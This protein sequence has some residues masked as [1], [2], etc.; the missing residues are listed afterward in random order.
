MIHRHSSIIMSSF[1]IISRPCTFLVLS[2]LLNRK[3]QSSSSSNLLKEVFQFLSYFGNVSSDF[4]SLVLSVLSNSSKLRNHWFF[5][6]RNKSQLLFLQN[7]LLDFSFSLE[8]DQKVPEVVPLSTHSISV[9]SHDCGHFLNQFLSINNFSSVVEFSTGL[10][11]NESTCDFLAANLPNLMSLSIVIDK[12]FSFSASFSNLTCLQVCPSFPFQRLVL[13][14]S[15]LSN[16]K[17]LTF[18]GAQSCLKGLSS[19]SMLEHVSFYS[20]FSEEPFHPSVLL[21]YL[22]L[23]NTLVERASMLFAHNV[24][25]QHCSVSL[26]DLVPTSVPAHVSSQVV[27]Y[28]ISPNYGDDHAASFSMFSFPF[29]SRLLISSY[30]T[31]DLDLSCCSRL[32]ELSLSNLKS[33]NDTVTITSLLHV[34]KVKLFSCS[35]K[36]SH[37]ILTHSPLLRHLELVNVSFIST[38]PDSDV[39]YS[40]NYLE[41]L[42]LVSVEGFFSRLKKLPSLSC[43][44]LSDLRGV[45]SSFLS[46]SCRNLKFLSLKDCALQSTV[47]CAASLVNELVLSN[48]EFCGCT[49]FNQFIRL[50]D[51]RLTLPDNFTTSIN[52]PSSLLSLKLSCRFLAVKKS[53]VSLNKALVVSGDLAC[54]S[55]ELADANAFVANLSHL[56]PSTTIS[57]RITELQAP[58]MP[59]FRRRGPRG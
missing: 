24:H 41:T 21:K 35:L 10:V 28:S 54:S 11:C 23:S 6:S 29:I 2:S 9:S 17:K 32:Q 52:L 14:V 34:V 49:F 48:T 59:R 45:G 4:R 5:V 16:L 39:F 53:L 57:L 50:R 37:Q 25:Y 13:D 12:D 30:K 8:I 36:V 31:F 56:L 46:L 18:T 3:D 47:D 26:S 22:T 42:K 43:L 1:K 20:S 51:L 38:S 55:D 15:R 33:W 7:Q 44:C 58:E 27:E 19:L 40:L